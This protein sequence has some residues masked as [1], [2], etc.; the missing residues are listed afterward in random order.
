MYPCGN[1]LC[2]CCAVF[3]KRLGLASGDLEQELMDVAQ[4]V[5]RSPFLLSPHPTKPVA[6][7]MLSLSWQKTQKATTVGSSKS[8]FHLRCSQCLP[9]LLLEGR[10]IRAV[11]TVASV[12]ME[13]DFHPEVLQLCFFQHRI[14]ESRAGDTEGIRDPYP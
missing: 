10:L 5:P 8:N 9:K 1:L 12:K 4:A 14:R 13:V 11:S 3:L 2:S 7:Q 6:V